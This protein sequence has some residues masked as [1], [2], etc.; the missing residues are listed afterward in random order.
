[1]NEPLTMLD[2]RFSD[3]DAEPTSWQA[4]QEV[5]ENAQITW[6]T[7]VRVAPRW[8]SPSTRPRCWPSARASSATRATCPGG[9]EWS[10][11]RQ[12]IGNPG[13]RSPDVLP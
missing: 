5:L 2:A 3:P 4:T 13:Y 11:E 6:L 10:V 8:C 12:V 9:L 7:T 1:M